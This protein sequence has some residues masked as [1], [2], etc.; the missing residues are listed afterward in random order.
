MSPA[1]KNDLNEINKFLLRN[2][3]ISRW[4]MSFNEWKKN[5]N[6]N[7]ELVPSNNDYENFITELNILEKSDPELYYWLLDLNLDNLYINSEIGIKF[8]KIKFNK[9]IK[10]FN[11]VDIDK[12]VFNTHKELAAWKSE[13]LINN[14]EH[15]RDKK[16][17]ENI[18]KSDLSELTLSKFTIKNS[19][20]NIQNEFER[21]QKFNK[22]KELE[23]R[24][25]EE[26]ENNKKLGFGYLSNKELE[27]KLIEE[28]KIEREN[29]KK[30]VKELKI[31]EDENKR[32][33]KL[34]QLD[35][36]KRNNNL[37][38]YGNLTNAELATKRKI[39]ALKNLDKIIDEI[40]N[41]IDLD[42]ESNI[43]ENLKQL[44]KEFLYKPATNE[45]SLI[46]RMSVIQYLD[47]DYFYD[48]NKL[49]LFFS[50]RDTVL[51]WKCLKKHLNHKTWITTIRKMESRKSPC[52]QCSGMQERIDTRK[53]EDNY[54]YKIAPELEK[55]YHED[56]KLPFEKLT[57]GSG[58]I[59]KWRCLKNKTH[60]WEA[61]V[62]S[63][64]NGS[65]CSLCTPKGRSLNEI[66][67]LFEL[68]DFYK[69]EKRQNK[70]KSSNANYYPDILIE[71]KKLV[72]EYDGSYWHK[73]YEDRDKRKNK[74]F[75]RKGYTVLRIREKPL[76]KIENSDFIINIKGSLK[77][78]ESEL[79]KAVN[80]ILNSYPPNAG[81][82]SYLRRTTLINKKDAIN[83][84]N[85]E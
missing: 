63:R 44:C 50:G 17:I 16:L 64:I 12:L 2:Y 74:F 83:F 60:I 79:K 13:I 36:E 5:K 73:D 26:R 18:L 20:L 81:F 76:K 29:Y 62:F 25:I 6:I 52:L 27:N 40:L 80:Y 57:A 42:L 71:E 21:V 4:G 45:S 56:N 84:Y 23:L 31:I 22:A 49:K 51:N 67:I 47:T 32:L 37:L 8:A 58:K 61:A 1:M 70:F 54:L 3:D 39:N 66:K 35:E 30:Y 65:G 10:N 59:V 14:I 75:Q 11:K 38:G 24:I 34:K 28:K 33:Y 78:D 19:I 68:M 82:E 55:Q 69:I 15:I 46:N 53:S 9:Q 85:L 48:F 43:K 77:N 72:I 41:K 7:E